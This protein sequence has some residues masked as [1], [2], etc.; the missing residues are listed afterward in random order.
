MEC[1]QQVSKVQTTTKN[2]HL[3]FQLNNALNNTK[4]I[5]RHDS[6]AILEIAYCNE[7]EKKFNEASNNGILYFKNVQKLYTSAASEECRRVQL[8]FVPCNP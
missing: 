5:A 6:A 2:S 1:F 8:K 3:P 4:N 7:N